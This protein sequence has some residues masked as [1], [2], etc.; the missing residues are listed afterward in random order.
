MMMQGIGKNDYN[1]N[2]SPKIDDRRK[3]KRKKKS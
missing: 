1:T 3:D 2:N